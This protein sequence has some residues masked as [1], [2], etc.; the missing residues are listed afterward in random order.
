MDPSS[1]KPPA[2]SGA[3]PRA[4]ESPRRDILPKP[5]EVSNGQRP[6][7]PS[8]SRGISGSDA[9]DLST[10][11]LIKE[12]TAEVGRLAQKQIELA[13]T[14]IKAD[15]AAEAKTV[16]GLGIAALAGLTT[17]NLLLVTLVLVLA[18]SIA[19]WAAGLL[20]SGLTLAVAGIVA[21]LAW[22]KRVR[23]P[24]ARTRHTLNDDVQWTKD[25]IL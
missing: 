17:V 10:V 9:R 24:L 15:L 5:R 21:G 3:A 1:Q 6:A 11:E 18:R 20:V 22:N 16:G 13:K 23:S 4:G 2:A 8:T 19:P 25:R 7:V 14:E 12:I